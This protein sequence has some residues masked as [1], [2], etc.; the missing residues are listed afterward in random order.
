MEFPIHQPKGIE[1]Y[2]RA[3]Q[4]YQGC[5]RKGNTVRK[6]VDCIIAAICIE[7]SLALLHKDSDFDRIRACAGLRCY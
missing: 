2:L 3:A 7:N 5:R 6:T 1:T 4:I